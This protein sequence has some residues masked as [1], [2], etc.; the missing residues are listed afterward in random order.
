VATTGANVDRVVGSGDAETFVELLEYRSVARRA[1]NVD[2]WNPGTGHLCFYV[3]DIER[4]HGA[5]VSRGH[6]P[7]SGPVDIDSGPNAGSRA[8]YVQD[9]DGHW[10]ELFQRS[11]S[12]P[13][14]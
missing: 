3:G 11:T 12:A 7:R 14:G 13:P 1:V 4:I 8:F 5:L 9:P 2:P 10:I 6:D